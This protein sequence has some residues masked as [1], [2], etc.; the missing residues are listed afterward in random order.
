[1]HFNEKNELLYVHNAHGWS[2]LT[3]CVWIQGGSREVDRF[4]APRNVQINLKMMID[5]SL[6]IIPGNIVDKPI[7]N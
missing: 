6:L 1:M 5:K 2:L 4:F 3:W 7:E